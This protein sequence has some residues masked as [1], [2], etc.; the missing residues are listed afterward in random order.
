MKTLMI[1][2]LVA[3]MSATAFAGEVAT[4]NEKTEFH[5]PKKKGVKKKRNGGHCPAYTS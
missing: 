1:A 3:L 4:A 5:K 2:G